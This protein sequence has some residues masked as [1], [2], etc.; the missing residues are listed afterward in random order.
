MLVPFEHDDVGFLVKSAEPCGGGS[1]AR[2]SADDDY[3]FAGA[4]DE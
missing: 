2:D 1:A 4:H 3:F